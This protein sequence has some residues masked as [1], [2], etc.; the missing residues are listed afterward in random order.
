MYVLQAAGYLVCLH[1]QPSIYQFLLISACFFLIFGLKLHTQTFAKPRHAFSLI[2]SPVPSGHHYI[3]S[4]EEENKQNVTL[5]LLPY[6]HMYA[7]RQANSFLSS[8]RSFRAN[9]KAPLQP[10]PRS[11]AIVI[12]VVV[13][14]KSSSFATP[15]RG[16][17]GRAL[18]STTWAWGAPQS[19]TQE[20]PRRR[21]NCLSSISHH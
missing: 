8:V 9:A 1:P 5:F 13:C 3:N 12:A 16:P 17:R 15:L 11:E 21:T 10:P 7:P 4:D 14:F 19:S 20:I 6:E 2:P 18:G